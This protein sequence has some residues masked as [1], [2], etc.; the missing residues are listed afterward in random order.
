MK[1]LFYCFPLVCLFNLNAQLTYI[2]DDAFEAYLESNILGMSN[3]I[4]NDNYVN[5]SAVLNC[6]QLDINGNTYPVTDLTG[7]SEFT[8]L[9]IIK[10]SSIPMSIIDISN[11]NSQPWQIQILGSPILV[12]VKLPISSVYNLIDISGNNQLTNIDFAPNSIFSVAPGLV[13]PCFFTCTNNN[14][15]T[16]IDLSVFN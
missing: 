2:P 4:S 8:F 14:S 11:V 9:K 10:F 3:G 12:T 7:I 15:I 6:G 13:G 16:K 5:T 1:S